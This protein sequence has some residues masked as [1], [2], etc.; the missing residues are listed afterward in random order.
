MAKQTYSILSVVALAAGVLFSTS[1]AANAQGDLYYMHNASAYY[2]WTDYDA[3]KADIGVEA[4][5]ATLNTA[6]CG[7]YLTSTL[8]TSNVALDKLKRHE[9]VTF[10]HTNGDA[11]YCRVKP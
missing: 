8:A 1:G 5:T 2:A 11:V 6:A 3:C 4:C 7:K 10:R 9:T